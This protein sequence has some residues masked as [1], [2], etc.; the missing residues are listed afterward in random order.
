LRPGAQKKILRLPGGTLTD[1]YGS[2]PPVESVTPYYFNQSM[3]PISKPF[4]PTDICLEDPMSYYPMPKMG[5][6][7]FE[8]CGPI[9]PRNQVSRITNRNLHPRSLG[10]VHLKAWTRFQQFTPAKNSP[11]HLL[12]RMTMQPSSMKK[13]H[14]LDTRIRGCPGGTSSKLPFSRLDNPE[15][16]P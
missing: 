8:L 7:S 2:G 6:N 13:I 3:D 12:S 1:A 10:A 11:A 15:H 4:K 9:D 16:T 14:S 5:C